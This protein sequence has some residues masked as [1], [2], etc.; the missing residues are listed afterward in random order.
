MAEFVEIDEGFGV[1]FPLPDAAPRQ[2]QWHPFLLA[3]FRSLNLSDLQ[4]ALAAHS[5]RIIFALLHSLLPSDVPR[6][7]MYELFNG[8][9]FSQRTE[10]MALAAAAAGCGCVFLFFKPEGAKINKGTQWAVRTALGP[11]LEEERGRLADDAARLQ[12]WLT[13]VQ[14]VR[15]PE[16]ELISPP[17]NTD[18]TAIGL[19][20]EVKR[21]N[22]GISSV[23]PV[24]RGMGTRLT[25]L[26][27]GE[28][29]HWL[30]ENNR[31]RL[32]NL[33]GLSDGLGIWDWAG[34]NRSWLTVVQ[35]PVPDSVN[36]YTVVPLKNGFRVRPGRF[37]I[38]GDFGDDVNPPGPN[39][40]M[41]MA[42]VVAHVAGTFSTGEGPGH[43]CCALEKGVFFEHA[44]CSLHMNLDGRFL[45]YDRYGRLGHGIGHWRYWP[46][47]G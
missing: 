24:A 19:Q 30:N 10:A 9:P 46:F 43:T 22:V 40:M 33:L 38:S 15:R 6:A 21:N 37:G 20:L 26:Q 34:G 17:F 27:V 5:S 47:P 11:W 3:W 42:R 32:A 39:V 13:N 14:H 31:P 35:A 36:F 28:V 41:L 2:P 1:P 25:A 18:C 4:M 44:M 16:Q 29:I 23:E 45:F 12:W 7:V 8:Q